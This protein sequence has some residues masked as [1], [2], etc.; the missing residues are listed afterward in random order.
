MNLYSCQ[1]DLRNDA[2]ALSFAKSLDDWMSYLQNRGVIR[3]W[4]LFRRKLNLASDR[5][6]DFLL[7]IEVDDLSQL[8]QAFRVLGR[9]DRQALQCGQL[10][11]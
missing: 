8:D 1:I 5:H 7:Q 10:V 11:A 3:G 2:R 9:K 6:R 4:R